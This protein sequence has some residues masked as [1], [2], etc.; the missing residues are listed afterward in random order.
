MRYDAQQGDLEKLLG[1][2]RKDGPQR[3]LMRKLQRYTINLNRKHVDRLLGR[4]LSEPV[5][6]LYVQDADGLYDAELGFL[7]DE[8]P[9]N[10]SAN[11]V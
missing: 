6:G 10:P 2:L 4:G 7:V 1:S 9:Y 11:V 8:V 5:P 3:W